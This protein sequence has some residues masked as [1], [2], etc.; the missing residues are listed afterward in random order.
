MHLGLGAFHRAHQAVYTDDDPAAAIRAGASAASSLKTPRAIARS[1]AQDGLYTVLEHG[2]R[3]A[4]RRASIGAVRETLFLGDERDRV[5]ARASPI[6]RVRVVTLTVT[7]KGYCHDPATGTLN[8]AHPDIA[9]DLAHPDAPAS[10]IGILVAGLAARRAAGAG[11]LNVVCCDNLPHN[12]RDGRGHRARVRAGDAI[13][14]SRTWI[15]AHVAFPSTMVDRIVPATTDADIAEARAPDS[16]C[17][18][19][20]GRRRAVRPVGDRGPLRRA[21]ARAGR[22]PARSSSP[23]SRRSRR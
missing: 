18:R 13:P 15:G 8:V 19:R 17:R 16:A 6:P 3:A 9:H 12:G 20:A 2:P 4:S 22:T 23:T 10:A 5:L 14:R 11:A 21:R 7:E 1:R